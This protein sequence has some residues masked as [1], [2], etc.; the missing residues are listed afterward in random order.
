MLLELKNDTIEIK[1]NTI[2]NIENATI[3]L[4]IKDFEVNHNHIINLYFNGK[5]LEQIKTNVYRIE[6]TL[7]TKNLI[8]IKVVAY[9][10]TGFMKTYVKNIS[11]ERYFSFGKQ[12][13]EK[14]PQVI[15]DINKKIQELENKFLEL[16]KE[17]N[18]L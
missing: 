6:P 4:I 3:N 9:D 15:L 2:E 12:G 11:I 7:I 5:A 10:S 16:E 18:L 17:K 14:I 1:D 13:Y 8:E